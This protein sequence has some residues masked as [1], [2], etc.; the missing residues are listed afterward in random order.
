M[1]MA[2]LAVSNGAARAQ[3]DRSTVG[4]CPHS[5]PVS[6]DGAAVPARRASH[7]AIRAEPPLKIETQISAEQS[8]LGRAIQPMSVAMVTHRDAEGALV[9]RPMVAL[10]MDRDGALWFVTALS[11][12]PVEHLAALSLSFSD[13]ASLAYVSLSGRG[14]LHADRD[15]LDRLWT[16]QSR[17][18]RAD[19]PG[20]SNLAL[21]KLVTPI[22]RSAGMRHRARWCAS[23]A[24]PPLWQAARRC[25][26][27]RLCSGSP[28]PLP[29]PRRL[30]RRGGA[31]ALQRCGCSNQPH[32][33]RLTF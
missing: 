28:S 31:R 25:D 2:S 21:L 15:R 1:R 23:S 6:T 32:A 4:V 16:V 19:G 13:T 17:P 11:A 7:H 24:S 14:E 10:E 33:S 20:S 8:E 5:K 26:I 9:S 29:R 30:D 22:R 27:T 3:A 12:T 18:W